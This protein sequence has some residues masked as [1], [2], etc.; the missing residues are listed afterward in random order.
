M[1]YPFS[2][3]KT[4]VAM[5]YEPPPAERKGVDVK[6]CIKATVVVLVI[7]TQIC[8]FVVYFFFHG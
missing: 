6:F 5:G 3:K 4:P 7:V 8:F 1:T 2:L